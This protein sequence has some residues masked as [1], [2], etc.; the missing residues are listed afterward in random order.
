VKIARRS[1]GDVTIL[2]LDGRSTLGEGARLFRE[3]IRAV[4]SSGQKKIIVN[5]SGMTYMDSAGNGELVSSFTTVLN[6]GGSMVLLNPTKRISDLLQL[7]RLYTVF[8]VF[9]DEA[10]AIRHFEVSSLHC[11]CP[12]CGSRSSPAL[13]GRLSS[14]RPQTC[15]N[16]NCSAQFTLALPVKNSPR[17]RIDTAR[18]PTFTDEYFEIVAGRPFRMVIAGRLNLFT[19]FGLS[20][21]WGALPSRVVLFDLQRA[22]EITLGGSNALL[23]V[24]GRCGKD[25]GAVI[26]LEG[27]A[28]EKAQLFSGR[29]VYPSHSVALAALGDLVQKTPAWFARF[30]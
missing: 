17:D 9:V 24:I 8:D 16:S 20:K 26:S 22:T 14:W 6:H 12:I 11:L 21:L 4:V 15:G 28:S 10:E 7:Q 27:L 13:L 2:D 18:I 25:E 3:T 5:L 19:S 1:V 23:S 30:E 29:S